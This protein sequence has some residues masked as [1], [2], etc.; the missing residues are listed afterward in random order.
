M[1][2]K[3][4]HSA[5]RALFFSRY[6]ASARNEMLIDTHHLLLGVL[7]ENDETTRELFHSLGSN[8]VQFRELWPQLTDRVS[9][10][11]ELTL[12]ENAKKALAYTAH[13][14]EQASAAEVAPIHMLLGILR[15]P[16]SPGG[17]ALAQSGVTY[18]GVAEMAHAIETEAAKRRAANEQSPMVLRSSHYTL[19]D[20]LREQ[21]T[22]Q[23]GR[24][25]SR[26]EVVLALF[27]GL[28]EHPQLFP[29]VSSLDE[30]RVRMAEAIAG[31]A[32]GA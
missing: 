32:L 14:A 15:T 16:D 27:D 3:Y 5:R 1:F 28:A 13:E 9:S 22:A 10:S 2:D 12:S 6:E 31:L 26:E 7:R 8:P 19:I 17:K 21:V 30:L 24:A 25:T 29:K 23:R 4:N 11:A 18:T 20:K